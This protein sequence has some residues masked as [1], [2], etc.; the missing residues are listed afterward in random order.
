[1]AD[2]KSRVSKGNPSEN[3]ETRMTGTEKATRGRVACRNFSSRRR[4]QKRKR[5]FRN[6]SGRPNGILTVYRTRAFPSERAGTAP[7]LLMF[8]NADKLA[9]SQ[10]SAKQLKIHTANRGT[11]KANWISQF[12]YPITISLQQGK[13]RLII[14]ISNK[15]EKRVIAGPNGSGKSA[16]T[17]AF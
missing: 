14:M 7:N 6:V 12:N 3:L 10:T 8:G 16:L 4:R 15:P 9:G 2:M 13:I 5:P 17:S 11:S 1:M